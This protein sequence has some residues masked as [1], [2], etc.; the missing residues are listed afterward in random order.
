MSLEDNQRVRVKVKMDKSLATFR[1]L[2][3]LNHG[4]NNLYGD[5]G[6]MQC[7]N[8]RIDFLRDSVETISFKLAK[9]PI[10]SKPDINN[11]G[12]MVN[13]AKTDKYNNIFITNSISD[14]TKTFTCLVLSATILNINSIAKIGIIVNAI[15]DIN[16]VL[17]SV[18]SNTMF[19]SRRV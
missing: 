9:D 14:I 2:L 5:D 1:K 16:T 17:P 8:C 7:A 12:H 6:E 18:P 19:I 10:R 13:I 4:C 15:D 3:W 11:I